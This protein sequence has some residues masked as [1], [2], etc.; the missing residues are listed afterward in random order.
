MEYEPKMSAR[1]HFWVDYKTTPWFGRTFKISL[2]A[3]L[4]VLV[5]FIVILFYEQNQG[6][7]VNLVL[8]VVITAIWIA[9]TMIVIH[10]FSLLIWMTTK[11]TTGFQRISAIL[12]PSVFLVSLFVFSPRRGWGD[13]IS[14][15]RWNYFFNDRLVTETVIPII[16]ATFSVMVALH[17][18]VWVLDGFRRDS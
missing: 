14:P 7:I 12:F 1:S 18:L 3:A 17:I 15:S 13:I 5:F 8:F 6:R 10:V 9:P 11:L 4:F 16:L 2:W